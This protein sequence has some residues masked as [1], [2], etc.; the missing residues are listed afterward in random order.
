MKRKNI[1]L[2][3]IVTLFSFLSIFLLFT[4][5]WIY[6][7]FGDVKI[8]EILFTLLAPTSGTDMSL[9]YSFILKVL[10]PTIFL[11]ILFIL[12]ILFLHKKMKD[13][14]FKLL[15]LSGS[16][17]VIFTL[18]LNVFYTN[19]RY[20]II[21]YLN[22]KNQKTTI[23]NKKKVKAK[24]TSEYI[25]DSSIIYQNPHDVQISSSDSNNLIYIYLESIENSFMDT[26]NGGV[27]EVNCL[28][29]LTQL[30]K[31]NISFSNT[32]QLGGALPFTGTTWTI[33]S[34]VAQLTGIPLKVDVANDMDQQNAFMP[35]AKTLSD[36]LHEQGY[37]QELMIGSQK[38]FAGTDKL[39]LQH[40]YDTIFDYDD[41][42]NMYPY[43]MSNINEWGFNDYQLFE[44][45]K[46]EL[47]RLGST[48]NQFNFTLATIDCHTPSGFPCSN[49]PDTYS[50]KYENVYACQ[51][52]QVSNF[53]EWCQGQE[54][55]SHT[56]I[57]LVG[58]HPTMAQAYIKDIPS[59]YQR[60]TYNCFIN[61]K[62]E[63]T[64]IKNRQFT[65]MDMYPT[66]LAAMGFKINGNK[67]GLGTN[68][69]SK[70]PTIIEKYG[71][72]Y[73]NEEVQKSSEYL[74]ENIYQFN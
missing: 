8:Q 11:V 14:S 54:W 65:H 4:N 27:K 24:K 67:L 56:T 72:D 41:L 66:T 32:D 53:I 58:D 44:F 31:E 57:I 62:V 60:T 38:E 29:E 37:I 36:F 30:A 9:V 48:Q 61:S 2:L 47:T 26:E 52:K 16:I 51:S 1:I 25:G 45:A 20:D 71:L 70:L 50:N 33:A 40:G 42:K 22:Y 18:L 15:K 55:Y 68:L 63:T 73:I 6:N 49:C 10:L 34:M 3:V 21:N 13:K 74:D 23:Y 17:F 35:G 28:P 7:N 69:F 59:T 43:Q 5:C 39:F 19:S 12:V 46:E 64:Q